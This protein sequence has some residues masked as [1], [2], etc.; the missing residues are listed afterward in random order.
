MAAEKASNEGNPADD[1]KVAESTSSL[2]LT[3]TCVEPVKS[4]AKKEKSSK[5]SDGKSHS[6]RQALK[7][8]MVFSW[9]NLCK[10][11]VRQGMSSGDDTVESSK[12]GGLSQGDVEGD[13]EVLY[14]P[15]V[16][17]KRQA[18]EQ[19]SPVYNTTSPNH[20]C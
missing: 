8:S 12:G 20:Q 1:K 3:L 14:D 13:T 19:P 15:D 18:E 16:E 6:L 10:T 7:R 2:V 11:S 17:G 9:L 5:S 4:K